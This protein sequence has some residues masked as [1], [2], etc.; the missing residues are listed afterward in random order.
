MRPNND[1]LRTINAQ[2]RDCPW[3]LF[4]L[5]MAGWGLLVAFAIEVCAR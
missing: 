2:R 3:W 4:A 5:T 1:L